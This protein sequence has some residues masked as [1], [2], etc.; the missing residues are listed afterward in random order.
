MASGTLHSQIHV[1]DHPLVQHK[2]T[3]MRQRET[4]SSSFRR[5]ASEI[6]GLLAYEVTRHHPL[7]SIRINTP[8]RPM[9]AP[10]LDG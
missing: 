4:S 8:L 5:L 7:T 2:L 10:L 1:I 9:T 3:L 6:S